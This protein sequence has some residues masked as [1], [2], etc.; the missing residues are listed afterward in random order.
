MEQ[1]KKQFGIE[2]IVVVADKGMNSRNNITETLQNKDG[3]LFSQKVRGTR[4]AP[5][6]IQNFALDREG[7]IANEQETFAKKSMMRKRTLN[8]K[9]S[10]EK[11]LIT[12]NQKYDFREKIRRKKS[13]EYAEKLTAGE[14]FRLTM[15]KGAKQADPALRDTENIPLKRD[16][17]EYFRQEVLPY[18]AD[19]WSDR[20]NTKLGYEIP[21][22][23]YF[24]KYT[25]PR[26]SNDI[27]AEIAGIE[28]EIRDTL[29][30]LL[31]R[32]GKA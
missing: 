21:F 12:W 10:T 1:I 4:G 6:D 30:A 2:R 15:K 17:D 3:Y 8:G 31:G 13:V 22:T 5:K 11:I 28:D 27:L 32:N 29:T 26:K 24:Y 7:W 16:I 9:E 20:E 18:A 25:P 19:A 14:R 23:R